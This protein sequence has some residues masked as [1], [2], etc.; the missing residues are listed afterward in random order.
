MITKASR[1]LAAAVVAVALALLVVGGAVVDAGK[2]APPPPPPGLNVV[3]GDLSDGWVIVGG[4]Y[5]GYESFIDGQKE[6]ALDSGKLEIRLS[7]TIGSA[8]PLQLHFGYAQ[9]GS[10]VSAGLPDECARLAGL[11]DPREAVEIVSTAYLDFR[12][13]VYDASGSGGSQQSLGLDSLA[14]GESVTGDSTQSRWV[15][16]VINFD[17]VPIV[18]GSGVRA[19]LFYNRSRAFDGSTLELSRAADDVNT[20]ED[21]SQTWTLTSTSSVVLE[22]NPIVRGKYTKWYSA[23]TYHMP[24][25]LT[26]TRVP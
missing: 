11:S 26:A 9:P 5:D 23:G 21:E 13:Y 16:G 25:S 18:N 4:P 12:F 20:P 17:M 3:F 2:P 24:F 19:T 6:G 10:A 8:P 14:P 22:C 1:P 15:S 7:P